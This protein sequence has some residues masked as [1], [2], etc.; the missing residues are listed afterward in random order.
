MRSM[1]WWY[2]S[3]CMGW[4]GDNGTICGD[5]WVYYWIGDGRWVLK[6]LVWRE[7]DIWITKPCGVYHADVR[8]CT[9]IM[10]IFPK[11]LFG[12]ACS[13]VAWCFIALLEETWQLYGTIFLP[14]VQYGFVV[15]LWIHFKSDSFCFRR[16][17]NTTEWSEFVNCLGNKSIGFVLDFST[18]DTCWKCPPCVIFDGVIWGLLNVIVKLNDS[19][20]D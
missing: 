7:N 8:G 5:R 11:H 1:D 4:Y 15:R 17:K 12:I 6:W 14:K 19:I 16:V 13:Q 2:S 3:I 9:I 20:K 18:T 10:W